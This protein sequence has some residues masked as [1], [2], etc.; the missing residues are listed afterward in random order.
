VSNADPGAEQHDAFGT[1]VAVAVLIPPIGVLLGVFFWKSSDALDRAL[2]R[3]TVLMSVG[4]CG[5]WLAV[6]WAARL[7]FGSNP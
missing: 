3:R 2:G 6:Y 7:A 4:A 1:A 5:L